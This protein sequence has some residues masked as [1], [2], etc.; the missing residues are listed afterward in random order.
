MSWQEDFK[1]A[2]EWRPHPDWL[3]HPDPQ[4]S[5]QSDDGALLMTGSAAG[6]GMKWSKQY[7]Q[8]VDLQDARYAVIRY[9]ARNI[10]PHGDYFV[11]IGSEAGGMPQRHQTLLPLSLVEDD[12]CWH[13]HI[14]RLSEH[15]KMAEMA[16]QVQARTSP[17]QIWIDYVRF[18]SQKPL[19]PL[20]DQVSYVRGFHSLRLP[21]G[22]FIP[23]PLTKA[24]NDRIGARLKTLGLSEWFP[25]KEI[26]VEGIPFVLAA[27]GRDIV[28]TPEDRIAP[29]AVPVGHRAR[30]AYLLM[31]SLLPS[32]D[33]SGMLGARPF[34]KFSDPERFVAHIRYQDGIEDQQFP[35]RVRTGRHEMTGGVE[36]YCL[37]DLRNVPLQNIALECRMS[38]GQMIL[39]ALTLNTGHPVMKHP[40]I[41]TIP[42]PVWERPLPARKPEA[43]V[44][45]DGFTLKTSTL[46][47]TFSTHRGVTLE[48]LE[49]RCLMGGSTRFA[50]GSFF[51]LGSS[52]KVLTS[53]Q[54]KVAGVRHQGS[55]VLLSLDAR[56][57]VPLTGTLLL[58]AEAS[59][60]ISMSLHLKN[61]SESA[62]TPV[63]HF[64]I[65]SK[66]ALGDVEHTWYFY[67][68]QGGIINHVPTYQRC[69]YSG[70]YP[71]QVMGLFNPNLS[72]GMYLLTRDLNDIYKY[73]VTGKDTQGVDWRIEYFP[74]EYQPGQEIETA[75]T[76]LCGNTGDWRAQLA[77]Y[78]RWVRTWYKPL[79][80]RKK[81]FQDVYN[82]RQHYVRSDLYDFKTGT[83]HMQ[84]VA[85]QD[86]E[87]FGH[88][89][90]LHIFDFGQSDT[91]GRVG[92]YSHYDE[93]GGQKKLAEA[94]QGLKQSG[95]P[96]GLYIEGYLCD[97]RGVWGRDH[98]EECH[99]IRRDGSPL[100]WEGVPP[101]H[102]MCPSYR[103]WQD[104][105]AGV[106]RRVA[107]E[108][109]PS[110]M[111]IDQHGF[112]DEG[113][114]CWSRKHGHPVPW[115]PVRGE[116]DLGRKIREA[117]PSEIATLTEETPTD[118]NSQIQDGA[119]G[120]S[121]AFND[122]YLAP[123][124]VDLFRFVFPDFKVLQ[125][126]SYND[127]IEGG[128]S[129][130]KHPFFNA[131]G[132][133]LGNTLPD[134]FEPAAQHFLR[135]ALDI[136]HAHAAAFRSHTPH[137]LVPTLN[138]LIYAN[139]F[140]T[141]QETVWTL[142]N[143]D[144]RT[145]RG[146]V[147]AVDHIKGATYRDEW[148]QKDL[149]PDIK[150]GRAILKITLGPREVGCVAQRRPAR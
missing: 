38:K 7:P 143:A 43:I 18:T 108:L 117:V 87:F 79:A 15:F 136:L 12:G 16:I 32:E 47:A 84:E 65:L 19:I 30:E 49:N 60:E 58:K 69:P 76:A 34:L 68:R 131:E 97:E 83:Y 110:G 28:S 106:Y 2:G 122:P 46:T 116:R 82:Y 53:D 75:E 36:A 85:E 40:C 10:A 55:G 37:T 31:A 148:N 17:A 147:L 73:F 11:W 92:D 99:I 45:G 133:W 149:K 42:S 95:V 142:F 137:P 94:I 57:G 127:F 129:L 70:R 22:E 105:L 86:R 128:W 88:L 90:Y 1:Q 111:Y 134:G 52:E 25:A 63:V 120:Y 14:A 23:V 101:E 13:V 41:A 8:S 109:R 89:D 56:P 51:E 115:P 78:R 20:S 4:A 146:P 126:V 74:R 91:Y 98:V 114:T 77:A 96:V 107:G 21:K 121:V 124:R 140:P 29:I 62:L 104:Y 35:L 118:F 113:K 145:Y 93:I 64:P 139:A 9:R 67:A 26:T 81:W 112:G 5:I 125:L 6:K 54:V 102:M 50:K 44:A 135:R 27:G 144:Y 130:L 59:G 138:P 123:H 119:L 24:A 39:A 72:G 71:L 61:V 33:M 48:S 150:E 103:V 66:V 80:P 100:L 141:Q 132:W 3:A